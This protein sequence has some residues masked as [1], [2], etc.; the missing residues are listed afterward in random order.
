MARKAATQQVVEK[1]E[2]F[3]RAQVDEIVQQALERAM[4]GRSVQNAAVEQAQ[5]E[6][7]TTSTAEIA[8]S[9]ASAARQMLA[10]GVTIK[11]QEDGAERILNCLDP[12]PQTSNTRTFYCWFGGSGK[13][14]GVEQSL[15]PSNMQ[16][17]VGG[18]RRMDA[19]NRVINAPFKMIEFVDGI[20]RT[21]D[22]DLIAVLERMMKS[23]PNITEN[24]DEYLS[25]I[26]PQDKAVDRLE[27]RLKEAREEVNRLK[28][29][30]ATGQA[31]R[32]DSAP[33][34]VIGPIS[35]GSVPRRGPNPA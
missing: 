23:S 35:S 8:Q 1:E 14:N 31:P 28:A 13:V 3:T 12:P 32:V 11:L 16:I 22:P 15:R 29:Q 9:A 5:E 33:K 27:A 20:F 19:S 7:V 4:A 25:K 17:P 18:E 24:Q 21:E 2:T 6:G 10:P 26:L 30:F 34:S